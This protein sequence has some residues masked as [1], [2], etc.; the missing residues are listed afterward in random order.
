M[1]VC[2]FIATIEVGLAMYSFY[3]NWD[4]K[5]LKNLP[6][7][8][9]LQKELELEFEPRHPDTK[10]CALALDM[11]LYNIPFYRLFYNTKSSLQGQN[12]FL[13]IKCAIFLLC[14]WQDD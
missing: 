12:W 5:K 2:Y 1:C 4:T 13:I 11:I 10:A 7:E 6:L 3:R 8:H 14:F 9:L